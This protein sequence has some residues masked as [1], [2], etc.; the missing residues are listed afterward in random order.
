M[1]STPN[2][3][4]QD[5][6]ARILEFIPKL[7]I[8]KWL[9][10]DVRILFK[11]CYW[12]GLRFDEA[13]H[14]KYE[15]IDLERREIFLG[16][17]KTEKNGIAVIA[18]PFV[19]EL[20]DWLATKKDGELFPG[21]TYDTAYKWICRMGKELDIIAWT[22]PQSVS[23]EKTKTHIFRKSIGKDMMFATHKK[24]NAPL[25]IISQQLRHKDLKSTQEYLKVGDE[26]VKEYWDE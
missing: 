8:R 6:F 14:L 5:D 12:C 25:N 18:D 16:Q 10:E 21:L 4:N 13:C 15:N 17:T 2:Y 11:I 24:K 23:G 19:D 1:R 9:D 26:V 7:K 20:V 22:T 3:I